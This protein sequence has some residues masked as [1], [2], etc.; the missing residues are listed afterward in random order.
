MLRYTNPCLHSPTHRVPFLSNNMYINTQVGSRRHVLIHG[1]QSI[2]VNLANLHAQD[3][4]SVFILPVHRLGPHFMERVAVFLLLLEKFFG[5][6]LVTPVGN[7]LPRVAQKTEMN[8][9]TA[10]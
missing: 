10:R 8:G 9:S 5:A 3:I 4:M 2:G 7:H 1:A 6:D